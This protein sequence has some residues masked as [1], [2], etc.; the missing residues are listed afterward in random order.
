MLYYHAAIRY[1]KQQRAAQTIDT[2]QAFVG[3]KAADN[4][5]QKLTS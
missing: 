2:N 1:D 5:I 4:H 3:G